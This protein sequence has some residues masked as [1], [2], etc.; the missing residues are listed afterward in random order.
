MAVSAISASVCYCFLLIV[1]TLCDVN[2]SII[3]D[4]W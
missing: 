1:V 4:V 3:L 2:T